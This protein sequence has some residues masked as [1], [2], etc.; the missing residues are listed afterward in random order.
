MTTGTCMNFCSC[1]SHPNFS[2][3][4]VRRLVLSIFCIVRSLGEA[5]LLSLN[6]NALALDGCGM[7]TRRS[8]TFP[9]SGSHTIMRPYSRRMGEKRSIHFVDRSTM[10]Y[11]L[12]WDL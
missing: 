1:S 5:R 12:D 6:S 4:L 11:L 10:K 2:S 7:L 9:S 3:Q 8:L